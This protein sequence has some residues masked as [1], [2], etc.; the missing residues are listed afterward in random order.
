MIFNN[1]KD[2]NGEDSEYHELADTMLE[3]CG[4]L[5]KQIKQTDPLLDEDEEGGGKRKKKKSLS[6]DLT[7]ESSE[8]SSE[9]EGVDENEE[10]E[11]D[12]KRSKKKKS[13]RGIKEG[14]LMFKPQMVQPTHPGM[15]RQMPPHM[16]HP[17]MRPPPEMMG[18]AGGY[19][20]HPYYGGQPMR[21]HYPN[22]PMQMRPHPREPYPSEHYRYPPYM[23][24]GGMPPPA[25]GPPMMNPEQQMMHHQRMMA[26]HSYPMN[27]SGPPMMMSSHPGPPMMM[28]SHPGPRM[29]G[30]PPANQEAP[31]TTK[32]GGNQRVSSPRVSSTVKTPPTSG[33]EKTGNNDECK[34][35]A[36]EEDK[37]NAE[38]NNET[39]K[40]LDK[41]PQTNGPPASNAPPTQSPYPSGQPHPSYP[42]HY[43]QQMRG[44]HPTQAMMDERQRYMHA[45]MMMRRQQQQY[46]MAQGYP[47]QGHPSEDPYYNRQQRPALPPYGPHP[48]QGNMMDEKQKYMEYQMRVRNAAAAASG[49][50]G[51]ELQ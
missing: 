50:P 23:M 24:N 14:G 41:P 11:G 47:P 7:S 17:H 39:P 46:M 2:Y 26:Q 48:S 30:Q 13:S 12:G 9:D 49:S 5:M 36:N 15:F 8:E 31:P 29:P 35:G 51:T 44:L 10:E 42:P 21:P 6:P 28:S 22:H 40:E 3:L 18:G 34:E 25:Y 19:P 16:M 33:D 20:P 43:M 27:G 32:E 38:G 1:C 37:P 4:K 45:M